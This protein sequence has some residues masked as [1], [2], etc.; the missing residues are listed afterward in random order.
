LERLVE[1]MAATLDKPALPLW[2][3]P[4]NRKARDEWVRWPP[5]ARLAYL[6]TRDGLA[7]QAR[8]A[9]EPSVAWFWFVLVQVLLVAFVVLLSAQASDRRSP[10]SQRSETKAREWWLCA[11]P[12]SR[13]SSCAVSGTWGLASSRPVIVKVSQK[14]LG[15]FLSL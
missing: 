6:A 2:V 3:K 9:S 4:K 1:G 12:M 5:A 8:K 15:T 13:S 7:S 11:V 10:A 14:D